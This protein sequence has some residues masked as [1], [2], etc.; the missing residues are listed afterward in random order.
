MVAAT[1]AIASA[2]LTGLMTFLRPGDDSLNHRNASAGYRVLQE[3]LRTFRTVD[4]SSGLPYPDLRM[5]FDDLL[6]TWSD[7]EEAGPH[8]RER[9]YRRASAEVAKRLKADG[10]AGIELH[11]H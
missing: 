11:P 3:K 7:L 2:A 8:V 10:S 5:T 9:T 6:K 1:L 4:A